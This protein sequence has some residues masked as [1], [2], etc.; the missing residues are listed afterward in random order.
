MEILP[1]RNH[2]KMA[3]NYHFLDRKTLSKIQ[4]IKKVKKKITQIPVN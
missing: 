2:P 1:K 4:N 3:Q